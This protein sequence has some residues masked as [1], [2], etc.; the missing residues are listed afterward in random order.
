MKIKPLGIMRRLVIRYEVLTKKFISQTQEGVQPKYPFDKNDVYWE[1]NS[2]T[3]GLVKNSE[4]DNS[5][6]F[7]HPERYQ[8]YS[9]SCIFEPALYEEIHRACTCFL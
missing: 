2:L 4:R 6:T 3:L 9:A 8:I 5:T 1:L 7:L